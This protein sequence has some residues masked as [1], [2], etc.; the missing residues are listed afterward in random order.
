M[1][2]TIPTKTSISHTLSRLEDAQREAKECAAVLA[3]HFAALAH[4]ADNDERARVA[5]MGH[6]TLASNILTQL[7]VM[8]HVA[9]ELV[10][11]EEAR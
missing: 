8:L 11:R 9:K 3:V 6:E 7:D 10:H 4:V 2:H 1:T 5:A